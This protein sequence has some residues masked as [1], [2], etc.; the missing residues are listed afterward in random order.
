MGKTEI[1]TWQ[2]Y[3]LTMKEAACYYR[4]GEN[5]LRRL[6][7]ANPNADWILRNGGRTLIKRKKLEEFLDQLN[8]I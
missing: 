4:I 5:K 2:Q 1:P 6:I 8:E 7:D 3:A